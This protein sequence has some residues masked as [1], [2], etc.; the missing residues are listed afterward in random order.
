MIEKCEIADYG[1]LI[2]IWEASV[3]A[4]HD[5]L[6]ESEILFYKKKIVDEYFDLVKLNKLVIDGEIVGFIGIKDE[7]L[8]MLFLHPNYLHKGYGKL[9]LNFAMNSHRITKVDV[10]SENKSAYEFYKSMDFKPFDVSEKDGEGNDHP[11][12]HLVLNNSFK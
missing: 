3:R 4:T 2:E 12:I 9:L 1:Q 11:I 10:N 8:E 6:T 5:F 7:K